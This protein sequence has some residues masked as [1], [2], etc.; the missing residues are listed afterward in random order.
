MTAG[1]LITQTLQFVASAALGAAIV[2]MTLGV[3]GLRD[4]SRAYCPACRKER[5][6]PLAE[7]CGACGSARAP[8]PRVKRPAW[9]FLATA[10][11]LV[12]AAFGA[13]RFARAWAMPPDPLREASMAELVRRSAGDATRASA[14][15][16][17]LRRRLDA[18][19]AMPA[20]LREVLRETLRDGPATAALPLIAAWSLADDAADEEYLG[21]VAD[22]VFPPISLVR[23]ELLRE[24][25]PGVIHLRCDERSNRSGPLTRAL[26]VTG[27]RPWGETSRGAT[28]EPRRLP[29]TIDRT[30]MPDAPTHA[31]FLFEVDVLL[32]DDFDGARLHD[33]R[34]GLRD[35]SLW[36]EPIGRVRRTAASP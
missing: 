27:A 28:F 4:R 17:E 12:G 16:R 24:T 25:A 36:P 20:D 6:P 35:P 19:E 11:L 3:A 13:E 5:R 9:G 33:P 8:R 30:G 31:P 14:P 29:A 21:L 23:E 18:S 2:I 26:L 10:T 7:P 22:G 32:Y 15:I 1:D 34:G